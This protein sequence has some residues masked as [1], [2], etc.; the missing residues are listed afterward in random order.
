MRPTEDVVVLA[1]TNRHEVL[2]PALL[3]AGRF[4]RHISID[5]PTLPERT[6]MFDLYL[7][8]YKLQDDPKVF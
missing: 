5:L 2:D 6:E 3:R 1:S 7:R 4:D 8:K